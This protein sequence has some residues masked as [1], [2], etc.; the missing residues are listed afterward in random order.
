M[1]KICNEYLE[2]YLAEIFLDIYICSLNIVTDN[3]DKAKK[4]LEKALLFEAKPKDDIELA[5]K[6]LKE[7][8]KEIYHSPPSR[9]QDDTGRRV[10]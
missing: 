3:P 10:F 1:I 5:L 8:T 7:G 4:I 9:R 2:N 6:K